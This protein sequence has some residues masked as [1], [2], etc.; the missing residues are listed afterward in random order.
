VQLAYEIWVDSW[1]VEICEFSC[2]P[3]SAGNIKPHVVVGDTNA[4]IYRDLITPVCKS[5]EVS[6]FKDIYTL[7]HSVIRSLKTCITYQSISEHSEI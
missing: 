4:L 1:E 6:L 3:P 5:I 2:P 7:Q